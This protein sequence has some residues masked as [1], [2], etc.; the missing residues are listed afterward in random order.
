MVTGLHILAD[1]AA[2]KHSCSNHQ[3]AKKLLD[4]LV[5]PITDDLHGL[6]D[7]A[8]SRIAKASL[9]AILKLLKTAPPHVGTT[10][11]RE[12]SSNNKLRSSMKKI[13][14]NPTCDDETCSHAGEILGTDTQEMNHGG[15]S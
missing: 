9:K 2:N 4:A 12:M 14:E 7:A 1:V 3:D 13:I 11:R 6:D 8:R 5:Q 10:L 15:L